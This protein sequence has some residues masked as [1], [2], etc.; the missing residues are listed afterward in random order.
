MISHYPE[1]ESVRFLP[2]NE[3]VI[4]YA[5]ER[6]IRPSK[7][8]QQELEE[9]DEEETKTVMMKNNDNAVIPAARLQKPIDFGTAEDD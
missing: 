4:S 5:D 8:Y 9:E 1:K 6:P 3:D 2:E 7:E